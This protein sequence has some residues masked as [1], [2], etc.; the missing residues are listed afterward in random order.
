MNWIQRWFSG[1]PQTEQKAPKAPRRT[2]SG[3]VSYAAPFAG[4]SALPRTQSFQLLGQFYEL[5]P[6]IKRS[7][8]VL[9]GLCGMPEFVC[10]SE[11]DTEDLNGWAVSVPYGHVGI[12][13]SAWLD[14]QR[15]QKL[16]Y[17]FAVGEA[18]ITPGREIGRIWSYATPTIGFRPDESGA[19]EIVQ[20]QP[21]RGLVP[22]SPL[23]T[24][25][26]VH[27][28]TGCN[29]HGESQ[30]L[31]MP[32]FA[33]I[34]NDVAHQYHQTWRRS[35]TPR[36]HVNWEP[37][38]PDYSD[39]Q[40]EE[41]DDVLGEMEETFNEGVRSSVVDGR[42]KDFYSTGKVTVTT[43]GADGS[44][45]EIQAA[46]VPI[47]EE[48]V[49]CTDLPPW[50]LGYSWSTTERLSTQQADML[51]ARI[52]HLRREDESAIRKL[53]ALRQQLLGKRTGFEIVWPDINL[54]DRRE[55]ATAEYYEAQAAKLMQAVRRQ[56]WA[57][58]IENQET[59]AEQETG[60]PTIYVP[61]DAPQTL[62]GAVG[63]DAGGSEP[64][65]QLNALRLEMLAE[66]PELWERSRCN[67]KH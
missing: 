46:K 31:A 10:E 59:Y 66:Y 62:S 56:R 1:G 54:Q 53:V 57:D 2:T 27:D 38:T 8:T 3:R 58:G 39:P 61:F 17:G 60:N 12:G 32:S 11:R 9:S 47:V 20:Q 43:I 34:W 23:T 24:T 40:G 33:Q 41:G 48:I 7:A 15:R 16:L 42:V 22:L 44:V 63:M 37:L 21:G 36:Y 51:V 26:M 18:E 4:L 13:L 19:F 65:V 5:V 30:Y 55:T 67:G 35:G 49:V 50:L 52:E 45:M 14:D 25:H 29:P 6:A 28:A 64:S